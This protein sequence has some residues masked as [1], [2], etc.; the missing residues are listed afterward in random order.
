MG[1]QYEPNLHAVRSNFGLNQ[2]L[3]FPT[4]GQSYASSAA[5]APGELLRFGV[6]VCRACCVAQ[7]TDSNPAVNPDA[8]TDDLCNYPPDSDSVIK[9]M[10][11]AVGHELIPRFDMH[12]Q[13][14]KLFQYG[15]V[16]GRDNNLFVH[17][18]YT[19]QNGPGAGRGCKYDGSFTCLNTVSGK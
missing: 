7:F 5:A 18:G 11:N 9:S 19:S 12:H 6:S 4:G 1:H 16:D 10:T 8:F 3:R 17:G 14:N 15:L 2:C 13:S